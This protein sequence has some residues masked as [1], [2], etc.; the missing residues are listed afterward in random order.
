MTEQTEKANQRVARCGEIAR[1]KSVGANAGPEEHLAVQLAAE[2]EAWE[3]EAKEA[4]KTA[5][6]ISQWAKDARQWA[7]QHQKTA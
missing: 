7:N 5:R 6:E 2:A 4:R 1:A 3:R